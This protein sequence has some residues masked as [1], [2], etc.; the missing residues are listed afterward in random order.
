MGVGLGGK[1]AEGVKV[2]MGVQ[3]G[4]SS[5][6]AV[7]R[8]RIA[9]ADNWGC[10]AGG[11]SNQQDDVKRITSSNMVIRIFLFIVLQ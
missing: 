1:V 3:V 2:G 10:G 4:G 5:D 9:V 7:A 8:G 11:L 6:I